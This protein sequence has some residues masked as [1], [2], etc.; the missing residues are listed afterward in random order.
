MRTK[1][2]LN[3][4]QLLHTK[5][6]S[7]LQKSTPSGHSLSFF[8]SSSSPTGSGFSLSP[9]ITAIY[10]R[11][12][13]GRNPSKL[14]LFSLNYP[15]SVFVPCLLCPSNKALLIAENLTLS[16]ILRQIDVAWDAQNLNLHA[17][18]VQHVGSKLIQQEGDC[19]PVLRHFF[20][21]RSY[22]FCPLF[23][24]RQKFNFTYSF[25]TSGNKTV[26]RDTIGSIN[27][28]SILSNGKLDQILQ[29][30]YGLY[31][32]NFAKFEFSVVTVFPAVANNFAIFLLPFDTTTWILLVVSCITISSLVQISVSASG[33]SYSIVLKK[34]ITNALFKVTAMLLGQSEKG[35]GT[36]IFAK[37]RV[38]LIVSTVWSFGCYILMENLYQG[39]MFSFLAVPEFPKVPRTME[40][41]MSS[42]LPVLTTSS[43]RFYSAAMNGS[44]RTVT[45][46]S[47]LKGIIIPQLMVA[48][49]P[50]YRRLLDSLDKRIVFVIHIGTSVEDIIRNISNSKPL[51]KNF[52]TSEP[53]V[54]MNAADD[55]GYFTE[56]I[57]FLGKRLVI[58]GR[59]GEVG[60]RTATV[61]SGY[62]NFVFP[63]FYS[64]HM[65]LVESGLVETWQHLVRSSDRLKEMRKYGNET[66]KKF[67]TQINSDVT[68]QPEFDEFV[69][70]SLEALKYAFALC[71][72]I[73]WVGVVSFVVER[74]AI[75]VKI[76]KRV[77]AISGNFLTRRVKG[78]GKWL[79]IC[80]S[81][82]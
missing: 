51:R 30:N 38:A 54:I 59:S 1:F 63:R 13:E 76:F 18:I 5:H 56:P 17:N 42:K 66:F 2:P 46:D 12:T 24:L 8:S 52:E 22:E 36:K 9:D 57:R 77:K 47:T 16:F 68:I 74:R 40:E 33:F 43:F 70:V 19:T 20:N 65:R 79:K 34:Y 48:A 72:A 53:F 49:S 78:F 75:I 28:N 67:Y 7:A 25:W 41:L 73:L 26:N 11:Y 6:L 55:L 64:T 14:V 71:G 61:M 37:R 29:K 35:D 39:A 69:L 10:K 81:N 82:D 31:G 44:R 23:I 4:S 50:A 3:Q 32:V 62:R 58:D 45:T 21:I 60:F 27:F 80:V 15:G